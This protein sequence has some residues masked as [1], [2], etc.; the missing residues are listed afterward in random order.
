[1]PPETSSR[2]PQQGSHSPNGAALSRRW[3]LLSGVGLATLLAAK[4]WSPFAS[5]QNA[6]IAAA[7][8]SDPTTQAFLKFS[9]TITDK[10]GL[11]AVTAARILQAATAVSADFAPHVNVLAALADTHTDAP[12]LLAAADA[13]GLK[14]H[15]L[16]I[17]AVW[18]TGTVTGKQGSQLVAYQQALMYQPVSDGLPVPTYCFKGPL[19]WT[20]QP[21]GIAA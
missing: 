18:Y 10:Q 21:P 6:P 13:A 20:E 15:A 2:P 9:S 7:P 11:S 14:A 3:V 16:A 5:A 19:W 4:Q 1:M 8:V 12:S 17:V